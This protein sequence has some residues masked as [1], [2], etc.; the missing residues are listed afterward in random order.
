MRVAGLENFQTHPLAFQSNSVL[1]L[2][3]ISEIIRRSFGVDW[4][5][6]RASFISVGTTTCISAC[7]IR[8]PQHEHG[9]PNSAY[10]SRNLDLS[11]SKVRA[12]RE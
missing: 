2:D 10:M 12:S 9:R 6:V 5:E 4:K 3:R 1:P 8:A 11:M 7:S